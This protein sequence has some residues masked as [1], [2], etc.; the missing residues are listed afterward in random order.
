[1]NFSA[2]PVSVP[3]RLIVTSDPAGIPAEGTASNDALAPE[4]A[5]W[6]E[7]HP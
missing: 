2:H 1:M 7:P 5:A 6:F 4:T 3:G